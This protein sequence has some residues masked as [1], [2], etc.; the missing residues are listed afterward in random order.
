MWIIAPALRQWHSV[1]INP[2]QLTQNDCVSTANADMVSCGELVSSGYVLP[3]KKDALRF[4]KM[5]VMLKNSL[6]Q[7]QDSLMLAHTLPLL[8]Q[9][10]MSTEQY[11]GLTR[12]VPHPP[13]RKVPHPPTMM[14]HQRL[15]RARTPLQTNRRRQP[16]RRVPHVVT[17][18]IPSPQTTLMA[19]TAS[20]G[21][22]T[23]KGVEEVTWWGA[24]Y[25]WPGITSNVWR[26]QMMRPWVSGHVSYVDISVM[27]SGLRTRNSTPYYQRWKGLSPYS[28]VHSGKPNR[29][30]TLR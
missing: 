26:Y 9:A 14:T 2:L 22:N 10:S 7:L 3:A 8:R 11:H 21:V 25:A 4:L 30:E 1:T 18:P 24:A 16:L 20:Q 15:S 29:S 17:D 19:L 6:L 13:T 5:S 12:K 28:L 27:T 23:G